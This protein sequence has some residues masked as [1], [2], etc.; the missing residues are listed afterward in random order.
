ML[1]MRFNRVGKKGQALYRITVQ[2]KTIAPGGRHVEIVGSWNPH[3]KQGTFQKERI[4]YW[5]SQGVELSDTVHNLLVMQGIFEG[6]K[7]TVKVPKPEKKESEPS[8]E[9]VAEVSG[10][11]ENK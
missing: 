6:K 9:P 3:K 4:Q 10:D 2:E 1:T 8:Q 7:R 5:I 11:G